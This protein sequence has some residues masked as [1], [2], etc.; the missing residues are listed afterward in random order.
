MPASRRRSAFAACLAALLLGPVAPAAAQTAEI[1]TATAMRSVLSTF[2][3]ELK[4]DL[5]CEQSF[6]TEAD[7]TCL[8]GTTG[9]EKLELRLYD[10]M[11]EACTA[12][13]SAD[14]I[15]ASAAAG[16]YAG[17][18]HAAASDGDYPEPDPARLRCRRTVGLASAKLAKK[19]A[20]VLRKCNAKALAGVAGYGPAGPSCTDGQ[21]T[22]QATLARA[23]EKLRKSIYSR[24]G[25][26]DRAAG[27]GDDLDPQD[28]L[29]FDETCRGGPDCLMPVPGL[30]ELADCMACIAA[31]E[32]GEA[33]TGALALPLEPVES[34][35]VY[36]DR[37][38]TRLAIETTDRRWRC[39]AEVLETPDAPSCPDPN[40]LQ[41]IAAEEAVAEAIVTTACGSLDPQ[42]DIGFPASCPDVGSCS[43]IDVSGLSG[44]IDCLTCVTALRSTE[45]VSSASPISALEPDPA[46]FECREM[47][48]D[49][50]G[51]GGNGFTRTKLV[52]LERCD[53]GRD[54]GITPD[55][56]PDER[57]TS[58]ID[59]RRTDTARRFLEA[60]SSVGDADI[61]QLDLDACGLLDPQDLG[62]A[63]TCP[64]IL[65]CG[66]QETDTFPG[67]SACLICIAD[68]TADD[69]HAL[70]APWP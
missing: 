43:S 39:E 70:Y 1:C 52:R 16:Q 12:P 59:G 10:D 14:P 58:E 24:C 30:E 56:C 68:A 67:L 49:R 25:G 9:I 7:S 8:S 53:R 69:L 42:D 28:A 41:A 63:T 48:G 36:I 65:G 37:A 38:F 60:C 57:A 40:T 13:G 44:M 46:R 27:G 34:C 4:I 55:P 6:L 20:T 47:L 33:A 62:F 61:C 17:I 32:V 54:C 31:Q 2:P 19:S 45:I 11:T 26:A 21:G 22:P 64:D 23:Q 35:R 51:S 5:D 29:G 66:G 3:K 50:L 15:C 18:L